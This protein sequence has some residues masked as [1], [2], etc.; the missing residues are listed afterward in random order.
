MDWKVVTSQALKLFNYL[1][2][3]TVDPAL[4]NLL[5]KTIKVLE[6]A[7]DSIYKSTMKDSAEN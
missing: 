4:E 7:A 3:N 1:E 2:E 5:I 6:D